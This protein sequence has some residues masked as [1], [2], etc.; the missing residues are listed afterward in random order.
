MVRL[1][2]CDDE[3]KMVSLHL[4]RIRRILEKNRIACETE[5]YTRSENLLYD[6]TEDGFYYDI[7]LLDI[8]MPGITGMEL[9]EKIRPHLPD[10]R[11]IF[12]TSH[13]E[14]A[15]DAY[16]LSIFRYV[17]KND[18]EKRL[19]S[20]VLDA[21]RLA[22]LEEG[23]VYTIRTNSRLERIPYKSIY[24]IER[25]GKNAAI[26][27]AAGVSK[28]RRT[29]AQ[30]HEELDAEEFIYIDRGCIVNLIYIAQVKGNTAVLKDG[31]V[32]PVSRSHL[33]SVKEEINRYWGSHI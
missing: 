30:I 23:R 1:A 19:P 16:E 22:E 11:I 15:I 14:Y 32:L 7:L 18:L 28:V 13:M 8:E 10:V 5:T 20:A 27:T 3:E 26:V 25:D 4:D 9:A 31:S 33:Q 2:I 24:Y 29:L 21:V 17:P 6:I 12:I